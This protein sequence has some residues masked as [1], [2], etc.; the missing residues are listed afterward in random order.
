MKDGAFQ[1]KLNTPKG[2]VITVYKNPTPVD[3]E[4]IR[5]HFNNEFPGADENFSRSAYDEN[6]DC[7]AWMSGV[8]IH[9]MVVERL[10]TLH[11][12]VANQTGRSVIESQIYRMAK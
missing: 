7:Y 8:A 2:S 9:D 5:E 11:G 6:G 12:V 10:E 3:Y 4:A 1:I